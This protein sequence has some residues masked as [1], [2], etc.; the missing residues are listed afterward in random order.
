[1]ERDGVVCDAATVEGRDAPSYTL[2]FRSRL[3][4]SIEDV[5]KYPSP[6]P[7]IG[8][9]LPMSPGANTN[10]D[11]MLLSMLKDVAILVKRLH[12]SSTACRR[13]LTSND[14]SGSRMTKHC[15]SLKERRVHQRAVT[16]P[17]PSCFL[18]QSKVRSCAMAAWLFYQYLKMH[19]KP[20]CLILIVGTGLAVKL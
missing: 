2:Q 8:P 11:L 10:T 9:T 4:Y 6:D 12:N 13:T 1:M 7:D 18:A 5:W 20:D 3:C 19:G 15:F 14:E 17:E 16:N